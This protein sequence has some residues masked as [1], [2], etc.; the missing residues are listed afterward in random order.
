[1]YRKRL[2]LSRLWL[3]SSIAVVSCTV[4]FGLFKRRREPKVFHVGLGKPYHTIKSALDKASP[5][6]KIIVYAGISNWFI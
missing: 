3:R 6:A 4:P 1:M 5:Y 2:A